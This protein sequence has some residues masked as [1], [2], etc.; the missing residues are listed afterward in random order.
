MSSLPGFATVT[1]PAGAFDSTRE[2]TVEATSEQRDREIFRLGYRVS[3]AAHEIRVLT[4]ETAPN[5]PPTA[6]IEVVLN[7]PDVFLNG[8]ASERT[9]DLYSRILAGG[10]DELHNKYVR[11]PSEFDEQAKTVRAEVTTSGFEEYRVGKGIEAV[12]MI[13]SLLKR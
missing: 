6:A 9:P 4:G 12:I 2:V 8:L 10:A 13:G 11:L 5:A 1:F 3:P 7:V